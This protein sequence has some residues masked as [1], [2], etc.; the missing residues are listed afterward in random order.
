MLGIDTQTQSDL[1]GLVEL[2]ELNFLEE[3]HRFVELVGTLLNGGT[4]FRDV[5][6]CFTHFSCLPPLHAV[7]CSRSV[8][9]NW[10]SDKPFQEKAFQNLLNCDDPQ[11]K[12][13]SLKRL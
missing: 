12:R 7:L 8:S 2:G 9:T 1:D 13:I 11:L 4:G 6:S 5:L 3:R 10:V